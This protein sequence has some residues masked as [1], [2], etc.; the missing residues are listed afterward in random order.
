MYPKDA[1]GPGIA[2]EMKQPTALITGAVL[3][4]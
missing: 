3:K 2:K 4:L 1:G